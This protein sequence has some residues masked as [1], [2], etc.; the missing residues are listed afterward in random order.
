MN[1]YKKGLVVSVILLFIGVA[2]APSI[3]QSVVKATDD[4]LVEVTVEACGSKNL[5]IKT[6]TFTKE[7]YIEIKRVMNDFIIRLNKATIR[8]ETI[9]IFKN[10]II[11]LNEYGLLPE[12][13]SVEQVKKL[14]IGGVFT[15]ENTRLPVK[16]NND[17]HQYDYNFFCY[18]Q[19]NTSR[20]FFRGIPLLSL[21]YSSFW[22][23]SFLN[24]VGFG[25]PASFEQMEM[26]ATGNLYSAGLLGIKKWTGEFVGAFNIPMLVSTCPGI[27]GFTGIKIYLGGEQYLFFGHAI[28]VKIY[29]YP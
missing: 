18:V 13:M 20:T 25:H 11:K 9:E 7:K 6:I 15:Q 27:L 10:E 8:L 28:I 21:I 22:P 19:G 23:L 4:D 1:K 12:G 14:V 26:P 17:N 16:I 29:P 2:V 3:N 24:L 5:G